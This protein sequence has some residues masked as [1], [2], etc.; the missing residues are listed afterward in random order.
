M[1][2][3]IERAQGLRTPSAATARKNAAR[4][5]GDGRALGAR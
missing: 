5:G 2:A 3:E 4:K 1:V